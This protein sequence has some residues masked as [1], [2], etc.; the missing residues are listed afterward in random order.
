MIK[1]KSD[2]SESQGQE[3]DRMQQISE[4]LTGST[5]VKFAYIRYSLCICTRPRYH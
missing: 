1:I 3:A 2:G 4:L 5:T